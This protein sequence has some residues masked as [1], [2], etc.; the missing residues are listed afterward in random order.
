[1]APSSSDPFGVAPGDGPPGGVPPAGFG[2]PGGIPADV[3]GKIPLFA[4]LQKLLSSSGPVNWELARQIAI[5]AAADG[6][7]AVPAGAVDEVRD[8]LRL[9]D[10]WLD[11]ATA[12][13]AGVT[14][15]E[16]WTRVQWIERT[17]PTWTTLCDP[18]ASRVTAAMTG[19]LPE[20]LRAQAG[21]ML[22]MLGS[23]GGLMFGAQ[24][25][26]ALGALSR[27]VLSSTDIGLPLGPVGLG[28][29]VVGNVTSFGEGL[30][31]PD[32]EVRLYT[33]LRE[34]AHHRLYSHVPW[35]RGHVLAAVDAYARGISVDGEA[36]SRALTEIDPSNPESLQQALGNGLFQPQTTPEQQAA[37]ERLETALALIEGW[38]ADVVG[39]ASVNL[40]SSGA[41]AETV[42]RRRA[43]GGPAEQTFATLVG[44]EL[45]PRRLREAAALWSA[46]RH[47]RGA[48]GRDAMWE[49]PDLLPSPTD[50]DDPTAYA[51]GT[52]PLTPPEL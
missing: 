12:L 49:H 25:G 22:G 47:A 42:R 9:A 29:L 24:V 4:E 45:R 48:D 5:A 10:V 31:V 28:A 50:L 26:Q 16:A 18:V 27:E 23:V 17:Q 7:G 44:L 37:L 41:L 34:A 14:S 40:P 15:V 36:I 6:D 43:T 21:P 32:A 38:V 2:I 39:V 11:A 20:E 52:E 19:G 51:V 33:A 30:E 46:V 1:M 3:A 13:P 35:L 8:A